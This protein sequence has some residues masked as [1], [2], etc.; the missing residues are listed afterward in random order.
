M[1]CPLCGEYFGGH[2]CKNGAS[3]IS[4]E[5]LS[6]QKGVCDD[7]TANGRAD[8]FNKQA[9]ESAWYKELLKK[10]SDLYSQ[11]LSEKIKLAKSG[12]DK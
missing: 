7:C 11:Y 9:K 1:P 10:E 6:T 3:I 12:K 5:T 2:E 8:E 4:Y